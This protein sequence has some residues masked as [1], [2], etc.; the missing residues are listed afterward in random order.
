MSPLL[1][2]W[3]VSLALV[4]VSLSVMA[5]LILRRWVFALGERRLAERRNRLERTMLAYLDGTATMADVRAAAS[6][7]IRL[8]SEVGMQLL[9]LV[10]GDNHERLVALLAQLG[11]VEGLLHLLKRGSRN[12]RITAVTCLRYFREEAVIGALRRTLDDIDPE[13]RLAAAAS[14]VELG[15][16]PSVAELVSKLGIGSGQH[17]QTLRRIFRGMVPKQTSAL[18]A[19]LTSQTP[20]ATKALALDALGWSGDYGV[21][22]AVMAM[23]GDPDIDLRAE[24]FRTLATLA[25]PGALPAVRRGLEDQ[26]WEVRTQAAICAGRIGFVEL[27]PELA[28]ML[29]DPVWWVR[30]RA[31][32]ALLMLGAPGREALVAAASQGHSEQASR[33]AQIMLA[34]RGAT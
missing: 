19:L 22:D 1:A 30:F 26:T 13:V 2:L 17:P 6:G 18:V 12:D 31:A 4:M 14:L 24:A 10:R 33:M 23:T 32:E 21:V 8:L 16:A 9:E 29:G 27:V 5:L 34:E 28:H 11:V 15:S 7:R 25:H 3:L 20:P